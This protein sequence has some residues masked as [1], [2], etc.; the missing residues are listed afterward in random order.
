[1][2]KSV[3]IVKLGI[4]RVTAVLLVEKGRTNVT[5]MQAN[6]AFLAPNPTPDPSLA[7]VTA[8]CDTLE[9]AA[10]AYEFNGGKL[11]KEARDIS[12]GTLKKLMRELGAY[13]QIASGGVKEVIL[14]AGF[15]VVKD[16]VSVGIPATPK[17]VLAR[18]TG[19]LR[20]IEVSWGASRGH[21]LYKL[22][23]TEGDNTLETG[24]ELVAETGKVRYMDNGLERFKT[25]SYKV[26][27]VGAA[28]NSQA[29]D[30]TVATAA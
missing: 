23:R 9:T 29:S 20:Q 11:E 25:Y 16:P 17:N 24:W 30:V 8:A 18:A 6:P 14:S 5:M 21:R 7:E 2:K 10:A 22:Y 27:A 13:V 12:F 3:Y 4:D 15:D 26:V 1:M 28:G 19:A